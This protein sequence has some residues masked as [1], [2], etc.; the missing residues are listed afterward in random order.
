MPK[1]ILKLNYVEELG[2]NR[3]VKIIEKTDEIYV[4]IREYNDDGTS[5]LNKG[6]ELTLK[7]WKLLC[8]NSD[9]D[10]AI[11]TMKDG[12]FIIRLGLNVDLTHKIGHIATAKP[13]ET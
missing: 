8:D 12:V 5:T 10:K 3:C 9:F 11:A 2:Q 13:R 1:S 6:H 4:H 7:R